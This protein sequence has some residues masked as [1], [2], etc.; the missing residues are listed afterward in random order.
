M[1]LICNKRST[2][3][4][5]VIIST[6]IFS[7]VMAGMVGVFVAGKRHVLHARERMTG[8]EMGRLFLEPLQ[9][10]VRQDNWDT[11]SNALRVVGSNYTTY[12]DSIVGHTQN[13]ACPSERKV[14]NITYTAEYNVSYPTGTT[15]LRRVTAKVGWVEN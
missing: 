9:L 4:F 6:V 12:C 3:L 10:A 5:E 2:T 14:N 15:N 1:S 13:P 11:A 7:L 8:G